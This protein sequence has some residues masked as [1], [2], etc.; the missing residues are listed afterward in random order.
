MY[1]LNIREVIP[2]L[3]PPPPSPDA[4]PAA[5]QP[6]GEAAAA[7]VVHAAD[8]AGEEEGDP[9]HDHAGAG[10]SASLLQLPAVEGPEDRLPEVGCLM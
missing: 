5:V 2:G 7:E 10:P 6:P 3:C 9:G 4:V 8:G 1:L